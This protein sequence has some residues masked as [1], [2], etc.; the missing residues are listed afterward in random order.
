VQ[1]GEAACAR[2]P[3]DRPLTVTPIS[4]TSGRI[5]DVKSVALTFGKRRRPAVRSR[6]ARAPRGFVSGGSS[7]AAGSTGVDV[8]LMYSEESVTL[9]EFKSRPLGTMM[10]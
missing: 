7:V 6:M 9:P 3:S 2:H 10:G 5:N 4:S 8:G 1:L